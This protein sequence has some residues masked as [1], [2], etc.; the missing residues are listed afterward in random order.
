MNAIQKLAA[1]KRLIVD[2]KEV[3]WCIAPN[4]F[5]TNSA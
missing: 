3:R 1:V 2:L 4:E 5:N